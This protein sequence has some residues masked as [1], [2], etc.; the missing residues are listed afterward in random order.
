MMVLEMVPF[1]LA[2]VTMAAD[3]PFALHHGSRVV[4]ALFDEEERLFNSAKARRILAIKHIL[5]NKKGGSKPGRIKRLNRLPC[6]WLIQ[7][8]GDAPVYPSSNFK[9]TFGVPKSIFFELHEVVG[10]RIQCGRACD[11]TPPIS[12]EVLLLMTLRMLRTGNSCHQFDDQVGIAKSTILKKFKMIILIIEEVFLRKYIT[13]IFADEERIRRATLE[14]FA[15]RGFPGCIGSMDCTHFKWRC[16]KSLQAS[17][18]VPLALS[19]AHWH[20]H[21]VTRTHTHAH[22][23]THTGTHVHCRTHT[24][25]HTIPTPIRTRTRTPGTPSPTPIPRPTP[26]Q[27]PH[28]PTHPYPHPHPHGVF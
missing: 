17:H 8:F 25:T 26:T 7:Y 12:T 18:K 6:L 28:P 20:T 16:P 22:T 10:P 11:G 27:Y 5:K 9:D 19:P 24:H 1:I 2:A 3:T 4:A 13:D 23:H 14:H 15:E 21:T